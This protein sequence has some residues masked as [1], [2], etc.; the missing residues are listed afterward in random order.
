MH[1]QLWAR[2]AVCAPAHDRPCRLLRT[3]QRLCGQG[4][5]PWHGKLQATTL[6]MVS[7]PRLPSACSRLPPT[8]CVLPARRMAVGRAL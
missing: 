8:S 3:R 6:S 5:L 2:R 1:L 4:R 7:V